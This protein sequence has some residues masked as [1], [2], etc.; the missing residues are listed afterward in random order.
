[1]EL[2]F[3]NGTANPLMLFTSNTFYKRSRLVLE[4]PRLAGLLSTY[5]TIEPFTKKQSEYFVIIENYIKTSL[6]PEFYYH[7]LLHP[8][9]VKKEVLYKPD[10]YIYTI[11]FIRPHKLTISVNKSDLS[12][13][14]F[15][16]DEFTNIHVSFFDRNISRFDARI[17]DIW[18]SF[19]KEETLYTPPSHS[20]LPP[21]DEHTLKLSVPVSEHPYKRVEINTSDLRSA[22]VDQLSSR[23]RAMTDETKNKTKQTN[24]MFVF[25]AILFLITVV[26]VTILAVYY[27]MSQPP[28]VVHRDSN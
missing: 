1:M 7:G 4:I 21:D 22:L 15:E 27:G 25:G 23:T 16:A 13:L 5:R 12:D 18:S 8:G 6:H 20:G 28:I 9:D 3:H 10:K 24:F 19:L 26:L 17:G 11:S 14:L 2:Y